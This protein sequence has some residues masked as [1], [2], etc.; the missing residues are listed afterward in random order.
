M[1]KPALAVAAIAVAGATAF[2]IPSGAAT[3]VRVDDD[4]FRPGTLT[5]KNGTTVTWRWVGDDPHN[6]KVRR[7]PEKFGSRTKTSG[8]FSHKMRRGGRYRIVCTIHPGM[9]MTLKV[10]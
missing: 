1:K 8:R 10:R 3:T 7:G 6:V 2:A 9:A 4:I 5:V